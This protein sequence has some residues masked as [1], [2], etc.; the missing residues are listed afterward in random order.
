[1]P[2][3]SS[4]V[5]IWIGYLVLFAIAVP[6]YWPEGYDRVWLG[7][8]VWVIVSVVT[9]LA[10]SVYTSWLFIKHWPEQESGGDDE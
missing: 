7:F 1:M 4:P 2:R 5:S 3:F 6:W 8:P 10:I 9:S